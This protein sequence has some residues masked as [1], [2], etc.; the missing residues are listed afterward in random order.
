M[1][2]NLIL[3]AAAILMLGACGDTAAPPEAPKAEK[4]AAPAPKGPEAELKAKQVQVQQ[5]FEEAM[6]AIPPELRDKHQA[7]F[8]CMI[9]R[10]NKLPAAEQKQIG[11]DTVREITDKLK[12]NPAATV[13]S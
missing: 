3:T 2:R 4:P 8:N 6:A 10:N 12:A 13:C 1:K 7:A 9:E 11:P 5:T